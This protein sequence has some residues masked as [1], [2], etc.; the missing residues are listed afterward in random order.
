MWH[1]NRETWM[2]YE[3][4]DWVKHHLIKFPGNYRIKKGE[5][6]SYFDEDFLKCALFIN[7]YR[8]Y[9]LPYN[10]GW[11]EHPTHMI[12]IIELFN[13][14]QTREMQSRGVNAGSS[15]KSQ[16]GRQQGDSGLIKTRQIG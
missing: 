7:R 15:N 3:P 11:I 14:A 16:T 8:E 13:R 4:E 12:E 6:R 10:K 5:I 2:S 9:G 1:D